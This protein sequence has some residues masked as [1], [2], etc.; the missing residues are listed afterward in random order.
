MKAAAGAAF[1]TMPSLHRGLRFL[2]SEKETFPLQ[3]LPLPGAARNLP[4]PPVADHEAFPLRWQRHMPNSIA[5]LRIRLARTLL[6]A[7]PRCPC[8]GRNR[9]MRVEQIE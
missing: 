1:T 9:Q 7:L 8:C 5:T 6:R 3:D 4:F 2:I